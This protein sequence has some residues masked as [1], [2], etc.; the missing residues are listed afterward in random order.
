MDRFRRDD[1]ISSQKFC[2]GRIQYVKYKHMGGRLMEVKEVRDIMG[3]ITHV[4]KHRR[5]GSLPIHREPR[6]ASK[7]KVIDEISRAFRRM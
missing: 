1:I 6:V 2:G 4:P 7:A 5:G 3:R